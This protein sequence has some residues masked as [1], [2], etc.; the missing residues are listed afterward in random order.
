M[1]RKTQPDKDFFDLDKLIEEI[2]VDAYGEDEQLWAFRQVIEDEVALPAD[3]FVIGEPVSVLVI[4]YDGNE[5]RGLTARCRREDGSEHVVAATEVVFPSGSIGVRYLA[6]YRKWL[7]LG[8][9]PA[10]GSTPSRRKRQHKATAEDLDL[11]MP[12]EL[13]VLSVK[14]RV[15]RCR[16]P[17]TERVITL[18]A[19]RAWDQV[20]GEIV[21]VKARKQWS[22]AGHP[23][24]SGDIESHRLDVGAL[25]LVPLKIESM[26]LWDPKKH[27][28]GEE[29]DPI[30]EWARPII[31]HGPR[32]EF[33]M[34]QVLPGGDPE[35]PFSDPIMEQTFR[36]IQET[37][38]RLYADAD[39]P[40][41]VRRSILEASVRAPQDWHENA[42]REA[43]SD[44]SE[45]WKL[46][47]VFCMRFLRGFEA[48]I[49][50]SLES[51]NPHIR[52]EAVCAA[53]NW[54][55]AG[56]W[57]YIEKLLASK[58]TEKPLLLAA[59]EAVAGIR[60]EEAEVVLGEFIGSDDEDIVDAAYEAMAMAGVEWEEDY[61]EE[62]DEDDKILH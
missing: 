2:T 42:V 1:I 26:G 6:A 56:A 36:S 20:A 61:D 44:Q 52:Y 13:I 24:L 55:V 59:I 11:T 18:R 25:G 43:Y 22:Y 48:E 17:E 21:T 47:A 62:E 39:V 32:P 16:V 7:G 12:V 8:L 37:F 34:E 46:T 29:N 41:E 9:H 14:D 57:P 50:E 30:E 31:A 38:S 10:A 23:Y 51:S 27:Y 35:D 40:K 54:E 58:N 49:L 5:R 3:G 53:G 28:W 60:P 45:A 15:A 4:D 33:K 19:G